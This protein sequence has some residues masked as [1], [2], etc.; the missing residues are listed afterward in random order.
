MREIKFRG[1]AKAP[2]EW[3]EFC[4]IQHENGWVFGN[5]IQNGG[6][7]FI[8]GNIV[9]SAEDYIAH[10]F[11]LPV[12][13]ESVGQFTGLYD[14]NGAEIYDRDIVLVNDSW[15]GVVRYWQGC[16]MVDDDVLGAIHSFSKVIGNV[17]QNG[18][19]LN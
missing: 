10:E 2:I 3:F 19:L 5:F 14:R 8:V 11:W 6:K 4:E 9:E 16:F 15:K 1:K 18:E 17:F 12:E 7:P 13:P